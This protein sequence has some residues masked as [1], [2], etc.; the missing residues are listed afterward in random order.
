MDSGRDGREL[1]PV[2]EAL[3]HLLGR[4]EEALA[5]EQRFTAD[6][7]HEL[8]TLLAVRKLHSENARRLADPDEAN[9]ALEQLDAG[10]E[11]ATRM[12][13]QLLALARLD[14]EEDVAISGPCVVAPVA[15]QV[16]AD[17][18]PLASE[19]GQH[20][21]LDE[22]AAGLRVRLRE[23]A[24]E[25]LLRNLVENALRYSPG[26]GEVRV[27]IRR[28]GA[29]RVEL[30]VRDDGEGVPPELAWRVRER[31]YRGTREGS[32]VGLGLA[33]VER[34]L[35]LAGGAITFEQRDGEHRAR[36]RVTLP[37]A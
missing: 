12:V 13:N 37:A 6:A 5:R 32:G 33:I 4:L 10:V 23:E 21:E 16:L 3:N 22:Q 15:R 14:P 35:E 20:L 19:R 8:R 29:G 24:L 9:H 25:I 2:A 11:R 30:E 34:I 17:V 36:V 18:H 7:A 28:D 1:K 26:G 31:F 27:T